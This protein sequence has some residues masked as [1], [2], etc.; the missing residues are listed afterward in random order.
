MSMRSIFLCAAAILSGISLASCYMFGIVPTVH[1]RTSSGPDLISDWTMPH[2]GKPRSVTRSE[3]E[4][5]ESQQRQKIEAYIV[6]HPGLDEKRKSELR[7]FAPKVGMTKAEVRLLLNGPVDNIR[8]QRLIAEAAQQ[9]WPEL[10]GRVDE[11]WRYEKAYT[12]FFQGDLLVDIHVDMATT[13]AL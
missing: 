5:F 7:Q 10:Q 6:D 2:D 12:F 3:I 9:F 8:D 1:K 11:A 4:W 13:D